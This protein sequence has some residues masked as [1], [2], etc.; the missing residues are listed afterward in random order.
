MLSLMYKYISLILVFVLSTVCYA[1]AQDLSKYCK[2]SRAEKGQLYFVFPQ[3]IASLGDEKTKDIELDYTYLSARDSVTILMSYYSKEPSKI[4]SITIIGGGVELSCSE[5]TYLYQEAK[6]KYWLS[7]LRAV[8]PFELW[9]Q[10]ELSA[11]PA[12]YHLRGAEGSTIARYRHRDAK[13]KKR[14]ALRRKFFELI[15]LNRATL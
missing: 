6:G 5:V 11:Y 8:V 14:E 4:S 15:S 10:S 9:K 12:E 2:V 13:W 7:R 3:K 1:Y